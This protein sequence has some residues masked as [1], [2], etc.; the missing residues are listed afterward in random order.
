MLVFCKQ[1]S[2]FFLRRQNFL[3]QDNAV[4]LKI[5]K[6]RL[7]IQ[8]RAIKNNNITKNLAM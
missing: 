6:Q 8:E 5:F 4:Y 1:K 3:N 2:R 7:C